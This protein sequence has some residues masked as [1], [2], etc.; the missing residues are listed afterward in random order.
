MPCDFKI[1]SIHEK[2]IKEN[3]YDIEMFGV[4]NVGEIFPDADVK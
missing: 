4:A 2:L 1:K 3:Y